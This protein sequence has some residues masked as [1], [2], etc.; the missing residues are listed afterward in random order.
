MIFDTRSTVALIGL[1][2]ALGGCPVEP[3]KYCTTENPKCHENYT[4]DSTDTQTCLRSCITNDQC[5]SSQT[6]DEANGVCR[7]KEPTTP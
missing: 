3:H 2:V 7:H 6:C 1:V 5:L 4:C